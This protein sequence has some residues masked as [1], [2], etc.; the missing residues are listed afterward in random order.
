LSNTFDQTA[1]R[2]DSDLK[3]LSDFRAEREW[4]LEPGDLLYLPPHVAHYGVATSDDCITLSIGARAPGLH[5]LLTHIASELIE[6]APRDL[7][8]TDPDRSVAAHGTRVNS[9]DVERAYRLF[10]HHLTHDRSAFTRALGSLLSQPKALFAEEATPIDA[11]ETRGLMRDAP[12]LVRCKGSRWLWWHDDHAATLFVG[13][14][15]FACDGASPEVLALLCTA[16]RHLRPT[17]D[18]WMRN[19]AHEALLRDLVT[20][21][22]LVAAQGSDEFNGS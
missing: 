7:H 21:G 11:D 14:Q 12:A 13:G 5:E 16:R 4:E 6:G 20:E 18:R 10:S 17:L 9:V 19:E 3:I 2:D 22:W 15:N 8:L 1:L